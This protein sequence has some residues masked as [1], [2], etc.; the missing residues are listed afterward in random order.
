MNSV[1]NTLN[2]ELILQ[3]LKQRLIQFAK[4]VSLFLN[5]CIE[6]ILVLD[7]FILSNI[8]FYCFTL[9]FGSYFCCDLFIF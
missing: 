8:Y 6:I 3:N 1:L 7:F 2:L 9:F 5:A 4:L